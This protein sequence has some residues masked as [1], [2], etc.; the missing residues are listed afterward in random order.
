MQPGWLNK[1]EW[2]GSASRLREDAGRLLP[3]GPEL[4]GLGLQLLGD[5]IPDSVHGLLDPGLETAEESGDLDGFG[6]VLDLD[7]DGV[8][9]ALLVALLLGEIRLVVLRLEPIRQAIHLGR[10]VGDVPGD[11]RAQGALPR[12]VVRRDRPGE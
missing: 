5:V 9:D 6:F 4:L 3:P 12:R 1:K 8:V 10:I 11:Q 7:P 2:G